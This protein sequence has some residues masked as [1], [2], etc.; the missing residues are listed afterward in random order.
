MIKQ[1]TCWL[2]TRH[3]NRKKIGT[4]FYFDLFSNFKLCYEYICK[5]C[6]YHGKKDLGKTTSQRLSKIVRYKLK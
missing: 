6:K 4:A 3:K 5:D 1:L 2:K